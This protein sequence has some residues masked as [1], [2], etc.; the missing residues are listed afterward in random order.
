VCKGRLGSPGGWRGKRRMRQGDGGVGPTCLPLFRWAPA[1]F[2][3][4]S[5]KHSPNRRVQ[6]DALRMM[7]RYPLF[8]F[9]YEQSRRNQ[10]PGT[11][12][13]DFIRWPLQATLYSLQS[14]ACRVPQFR[15]FN[16][17]SHFSCLLNRPFGHPASRTIEQ[18]LLGEQEKLQPSQSRGLALTQHEPNE[19]E[20]ARHVRWGVM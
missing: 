2:S 1:R 20:N 6:V 9:C 16:N 5:R 14:F 12:V 7:S 10:V 15:L 18:A 19:R 17:S 3:N 4:S 8:S 13:S 11:H